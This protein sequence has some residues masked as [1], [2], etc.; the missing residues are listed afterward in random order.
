[1]EHLL[2]VYRDA[3]ELEAFIDTHGLA[4]RRGLVQVF[5]A[6]A[7]PQQVR[8]VLER[9][10]ALHGFAVIGAS[11][12]GAI[13][14][15]RVH[16]EGIVLSVSIF[17]HTQIETRY[18]PQ[19]EAADGERLG[20]ELA[21]RGVRLLLAFGNILHENPEAFLEGLA[22]TAPDLV[23][24]GGIAAD[25]VLFRSSFVIHGNEVH[26]HGMVLA[27]LSGERLRLHTASLLNFTPAGKPMRLT[28]SHGEYVN[29]I[30]GKPVLDVYRH[31]LGE[32]VLQQIPL[33]LA[34]FPLIARQRG[35]DVAAFP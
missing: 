15:E 28:R 6:A 1:M 20:A 12:A 24:A 34:A 11:T 16:D 21:A 25:T 23:V 5:T 19:A 8:P 22:R 29:E 7:E 2:H 14:G 13:A 4:R 31:Y 32:E 18:L 3:A 33:S 17:E 27:A 26:S 35:L 30:D 10:Q 9:L